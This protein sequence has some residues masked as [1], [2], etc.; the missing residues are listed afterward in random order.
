M[1]KG[2]ERSKVKT[3]PEYSPQISI[4][5]RRGFKEKGYE[6]I[7][8]STRRYYDRFADRYVNF[9]EDW[10][11]GEGSFS[12]PK[13][14]EGYET[15]ANL[16]GKTVKPDQRIVDIGCGVGVWSTLMAEK[17]AHVFGLD[18]LSIVLQKSRERLK[19][20]GVESK[21]SLVLS[22]GFHLPFKDRVFDGATLNW[23]LAHIHVQLNKEFM[24]E[25]GRVVKEEGWLF[26]SDSYWRGQ[27]GGKEQVQTREA[28]DGKYE[29][30]KY[31]YG[32]DEL[33]M[34]VEKTFGRVMIL[35]P[36]YYELICIA[37]KE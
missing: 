31:Y 35:Q 24:N 7:L 16:L 26:L 34:L 3:E 29:V 13:Y 1:P 2:D 10:L 36:L 28:E 22:D 8:N 17:G 4:L 18:N 23:V 37:Q 6:E 25:V 11:K 12:D 20:F 5:K 30:Y 14:R 27:E 32:I 19:R 21:T 15:V 9:Y 33:K